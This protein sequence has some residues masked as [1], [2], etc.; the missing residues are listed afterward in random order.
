M[1]FPEVISYHSN[2]EINEIQFVGGKSVFT[3]WFY[4]PFFVV[5]IA[6]SMVSCNLSLTQQLFK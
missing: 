3:K 6:L 1:S 5:F 2:V 4:L